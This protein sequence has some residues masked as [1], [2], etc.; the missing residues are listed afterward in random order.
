MIIQSGE[1]LGIEINKLR[2][3][4]L[5]KFSVPLAKD[6]LP[7]SK[8][9]ETLP[10]I[11]NFERKMRESGVEITAGTKFVSFT[12][13]EDVDNIIRVIKLLANSVY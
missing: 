2:K 12:W 1:F 4:V 11:D 9:E 7:Q 3:E 5:M 6:N 8:A 13:N 10:V